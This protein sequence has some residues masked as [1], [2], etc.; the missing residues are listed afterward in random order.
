MSSKALAQ[1]QI[2]SIIGVTAGHLL[3]LRQADVFRVGSSESRSQR[4][5]AIKGEL[6]PTAVRD[7]A[8]Q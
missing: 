8:G 1:D 5:Q 3:H 6:A 7:H 4:L 2:E